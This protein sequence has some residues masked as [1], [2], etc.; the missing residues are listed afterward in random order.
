M[1]VTLIDELNWGF[2]NGKPRVNIR[3][4]YEEM[5][6]FP[7]YH[8][9]VD[10]VKSTLEI[11]SKAFPIDP[12]RGPKVSIV[13]YDTMGHVNGWANVGYSYDTGRDENNEYPW[14]SQIALMGKRTPIHPAMTRFVTSHEYGHCVEDAIGI[15]IH[16]TQKVDPLRE[17]YAALRGIE[18]NAAYGARNWHTNVGEIFADD[19]RILLAKQELEHW[20]HPGIERPEGLPEVKKWWTKMKKKYGYRSE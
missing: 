16:G 3:G 15:A 11:A 7:C 20:P 14:H 10:L 12:I 8:H 2:D 17:D 13:A 9:D 5:D 4:H 19:F 1:K 6:P 18:N